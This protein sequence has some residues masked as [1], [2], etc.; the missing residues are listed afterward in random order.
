MDR[1]VD[2]AFVAMHVVDSSD[3]LAMLFTRSNAKANMYSFDD[4]HAV[5]F[6]DFPCYFG[7][8]LAVTC[9]NPARL[10]RAT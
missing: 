3:G 6:F 4:Q 7:Y 2:G 5:F 9:C 10:Q 8:E 1:L